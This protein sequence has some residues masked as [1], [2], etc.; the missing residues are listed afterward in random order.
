MNIYRK[1]LS[2]KAWLVLGMI[3]I[4]SLSFSQKDF[5][6]EAENHFKGGKMRSA[7]DAYQ[8]AAGAA[9]TTEQKGYIHYQ[10]GECHRLVANPAKA[11]ESY[12]VAIKMNY[13]NNKVYLRL[14]EVL[15]E[16]G[17][18]EES[19]KNYEK[20]TKAGGGPEGK[21]G[22][23]ACQKA[24][25]MQNK[26]S[27]YVVEEVNVLNTEMYDM[28]P[29]F[30]DRQNKELVF[31]SNR[32]GSTGTEDNERKVGPNGD[33]WI[34]TK[35]AK[36]HWGQPVILQGLNSEF[37]EGAIA[38][39]NRFSTIYFTRCPKDP[40]GKQSLGC[41]ICKSEKKGKNWG[42]VEVVPIKQE[43]MDSV[44]V[45]HPA[46]A[47]DDS[48]MLFASDMPGGNG[49]RDLWMTKYDKREKKWLTPV[50]LGSGVNTAGDE[51]FPYIHP[52]T[53]DLFFASNGHPGLGGLDIFKAPKTGEGT[54]GKPENFGYPINS[55]AHDYG[56]V[57]ESKDF[58]R[59]MFTSNRKGN[60]TKDDIYAFNLPPIL[61]QLQC[62]V[63]DKETKEPVADAQI[64]LVGSDNSSI[65]VK[66]DANG[67]VMFEKNEAGDRFI[68]S[69]TNYNIEVSK[70]GSY[71]VGKDAITTVGVEKSTN[72]VKEFLLTSIVK[73]IVV[74]EVRYDYDKWALQVNDS[75]NSKDSLDFV[76]NI[77]IENPTIVIEL[78]SHTDCR[79]NDK[80]NEELA[81]KRAKE[82]VKYLVEEK[83][84]PADRIVPIGRGEYDPLVGLECANIEKL[85]TKAEKEAAHQKNRRTNVKIISWDYVPK[86]Q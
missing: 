13:S 75:V 30:A 55:H 72:F 25:E 20:Y 49:G 76:Y 62:L 83:G 57:F 37:D 60:N 11:Q 70:Q 32:Q 24:I 39:D 29:V 59:G 10:L 51:L 68:N 3:L 15:K 54:W 69:N 33:I 63:L 7:I 16:Q 38:F 41:D 28:V 6:L 19:M 74:P 21:S 45:G 65:T 58:T 36:G 78:K 53:G 67:Q 18:Y 5:L 56:I 34:T 48:Y 27:R 2:G 85:P 66:T 26:K 43:G 46:M 40:K 8:R 84:I 17:K 44:T 22:L 12:E 47:I 82:C 86:G 73:D 52:V 80:Y 64:I 14:A 61:Y 79:G 50:N 42:E 31:T 71:L 9:K 1:F 23:E 4:S 77:L 35:D 81:L